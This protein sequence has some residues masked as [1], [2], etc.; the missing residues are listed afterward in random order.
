MKKE[1]KKWDEM[2]KKQKVMHI[3]DCIMKSVILLIIATCVIYGIVYNA[4]G[5]G[6]AG[7]AKANVELGE[8]FTD[9]EA[10]YRQSTIHTYIPDIIERIFNI[11][12]EFQEV[13]TPRGDRIINKKEDVNNIYIMTIKRKKPIPAKRISADIVHFFNSIYSLSRDLTCSVY[14]GERYFEFRYDRAITTDGKNTYYGLSE[15]S[16]SSLYEN[17]TKITEMYL[18]NRGEALGRLSIPKGL[19]KVKNQQFNV[20]NYNLKTLA[21]YT[22]YKEFVGENYNGVYATDAGYV[23]DCFKTSSKYEMC[24]D[25]TNSEIYITGRSEVLL[26]DKTT[27]VQSFIEGIVPKPYNKVYGY[28]VK[29]SQSS[30]LYI[31]PGSNKNDLL[32]LNGVYPKIVGGSYTEGYNNGYDIGYEEGKKQGTT[33]NPVG[34]MIEPVAQ[35]LNVKLF[36]DFSIG[37]FFTAALFVTLAMSFMKMFAGG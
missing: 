9:L 13:S 29:Q 21:G 2:T 18:L 4:Q 23:Y 19:I 14:N 35:L 25:T 37:N 27:K 15:D 36:G 5:R 17:C 31:I 8:N 1:K 6:K 34:M 32:C 30:Y 33:I 28:N 26:S 16:I 24:V 12:E 22:G 11:S 3:I 10:Y 7:N 20:Y